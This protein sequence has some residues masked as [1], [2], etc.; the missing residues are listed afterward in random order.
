MV[1]L[2]TV[3]VKDDS[4]VMIM[5]CRHRKI[6]SISGKEAD[7]L[8]SIDSSDLEE[9]HLTRSSSE[10]DI[11]RRVKLDN[12]M[13]K[14]SD[15]KK[16]VDFVV[17]DRI[18][19]ICDVCHKSFF[20]N[21]DAVSFVC[22]HCG[23]HVSLDDAE[24][25]HVTNHD[26][27]ASDMVVKLNEKA[28]RDR[29][30]R[31]ARNDSVDTWSDDNRTQISLEQ[32][33]DEYEEYVE[34]L[35]L[36]DPFR[37]DDDMHTELEEHNAELVT[38]LYNQADKVELSAEDPNEGRGY[39]KEKIVSEAVKRSVHANAVRS[40]LKAASKTDKIS[41]DELAQ[42]ITTDNPFLYNP[43]VAINEYDDR[44]VDYVMEKS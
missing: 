21:K 31:F 39:I 30:R 5:G 14:L 13:K 3:F 26:G 38:K 1:L 35:K 28:V 41:D 33:S 43:A 6:I 15:R 11:D 8:L 4:V 22:P 17:S 37:P 36:Q 20:V 40:A 25:M 7:D 27:I 24:E 23:Y 2:Y 9:I 16:D 34:D 18:E 19:H 10:D 12:Q 32:G 44:I 42:A 29:R